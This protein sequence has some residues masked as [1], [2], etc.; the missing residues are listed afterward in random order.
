[1]KS[2]ANDIAFTGLKLY[3]SANRKVCALRNL[4]DDQKRT[5]NPTF[6][7]DAQYDVGK[8]LPFRIRCMETGAAESANK[9]ALSLAIT[10]VSVAMSL[11][12]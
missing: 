8:K 5:D 9:I 12:I 11:A 2:I 3:P 10:G 1:M 6:W 4:Q 7:Y